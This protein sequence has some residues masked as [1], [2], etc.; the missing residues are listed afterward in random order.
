MYLTVKLRRIVLE[1]GRLV[2]EFDVKVHSTRPSTQVTKK[3]AHY[4][5]DNGLFLSDLV[6]ER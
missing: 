3:K 5:L 4:R 1:V 6:P 2:F